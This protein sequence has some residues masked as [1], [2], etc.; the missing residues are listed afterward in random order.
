MTSKELQN[1]PQKTK[2]DVCRIFWCFCQ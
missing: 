1:I 2:V